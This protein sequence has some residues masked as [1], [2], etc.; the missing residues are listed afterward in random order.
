M[1]KLAPDHWDESH[2]NDEKAS[3]QHDALKTEKDGKLAGF[4]SLNYTN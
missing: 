1:Y 2:T 4:Y 3:N